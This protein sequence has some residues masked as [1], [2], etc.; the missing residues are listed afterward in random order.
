MRTGALLGFAVAGACVAWSGCSD[1]SPASGADPVRCLAPGS[2]ALTNFSIGTTYNDQIGV[3]SVVSA[4]PS[5]LTPTPSGNSLRLSGTV[6][7]YAGLGVSFT[8]CV[9]ASAYQGLGFDLGGSVGPTGMLTLAVYTRENNPEPPFTATGT[10][11]P[12]D[13]ASPYANCRAAYVALAV[14]PA[15][16]PT[17]VRF[18]DFGGGMP[19]AGV[20]P[21]QVLS[22]W[23]TLF[24]TSTAQPYAVDLTLGN[25]TLVH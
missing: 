6:D 7:T 3:Q 15:V 21:A 25:M 22:V 5:L 14:S 9:D 24:W 20:N 11:V 1:R 13:P 18:G 16:A 17:T 2:A 23:F 19:A 4:Y 12:Q 10:C 8:A